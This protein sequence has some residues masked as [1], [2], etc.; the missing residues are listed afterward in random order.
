MKLQGN[1]VYRDDNDKVVWTGS[2]S[3]SFSIK[4]LYHALDPNDPL[5][6][7]SRITQRSCVPLKTAFF[8]WEATWGRVLTLDQVQRRG[9]FWQTDVF[10]T[11]LK[12]KL[13]IT[14]LLT[15][16]RLGFYDSCSFLSL[17]QLRFS[18]SRLRRHSLGN[19]VPLWVKPTKRLGSQ[20]PYVFFGR[21]GKKGTCWH[22]IMQRFQSIE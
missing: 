1:R 2:R 20:P 17:V 12:K 9:F 6:F 8:T 22:L 19:I 16:Q 14:F 7:P 4:S 13:L 10:S 3:G 11:T 18:P 15:M 21:C 5:V